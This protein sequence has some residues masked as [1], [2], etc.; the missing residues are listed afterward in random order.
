VSVDL[1][2]AA[3]FYELLGVDASASGDDIARAYRARAKQ[4]HPDAS[5][6]PDASEKFGELV[7][8]YE[9]LSNHRT[10][11][12]YDH[13]LAVARSNAAASDPSLAVSTAV[14]PPVTSRWTRRNAWTAVVAG[15]LVAILGIGASV[16]TWQLHQSDG[17]RHA[18]FHPVTALRI[19][20]GDITFTT[21]DGRFVRTR[22]PQQ[23]GEGSDLGPTV[24]VRYDPA[25][26]AHVVVDANT[27]GRDITLAIV[28]LKLLIGGLVFVVLG[29]RRLRKRTATGAR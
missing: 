20:N 8:A 22:E 17:R 26:P 24:R 12:E 14:E 5:A 2:A 29:T 9:V 13:A 4:L 28:S 1:R 16:L 23:H 18:R 15:A 6:D 25:D 11:R 27:V 10:R 3:N 19:D 21:A 7:S